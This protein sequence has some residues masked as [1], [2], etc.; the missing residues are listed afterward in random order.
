MEGTEQLIEIQN[1]K[2]WLSNPSENCKAEQFGKKGRKEERKEERK[3][4]RPGEVGM[5]G[6]RTKAVKC[7]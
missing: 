3:E 6:A 4:G 5:L 7:C 2:Y 1:N